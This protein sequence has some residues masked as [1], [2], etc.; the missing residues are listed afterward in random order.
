[1]L[2]QP[3]TGQSTPALPVPQSVVAA[4][5]EVPTNSAQFRR[6]TTAMVTHYIPES[7]SPLNLQ[8]WIFHT[9]ERLLTYL[10]CQRLGFL[11]P[12]GIR[13]PNPLLM[14]N[15]RQCVQIHFR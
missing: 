9:W 3:R 15:V 14:V 13:V 8:F 5:Q 2:P 7:E 6:C 11:D 12:L 4:L 10:Q 1:M